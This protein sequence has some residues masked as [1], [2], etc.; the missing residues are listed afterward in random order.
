MD[1]RTKHIRL[2]R[3]V[4]NRPQLSNILS[5]INVRI[6]N[7]AT[8]CALKKL[9][10]SI[11][12]TFTHTTSF[13]GIAR[14]NNSHNNPITLSLVLK[15]RSQLCKG[16]R[17]MLS[18]LRLSDSSSLSDMCQVFNGY[19]FDF[20]HGLL[21]DAF[22]DSVIGDS[23]VSLFSAFKPFQELLSSLRAFA[24]NTSTNFEILISNFIKVFRII[25]C[26]IG[27]NGNASYT[28]IYSNKF[29]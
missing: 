22:T 21:Y 17:V 5:G 3:A 6:S 9:A 14:V 26:P 28:K 20:R 15:E 13:A 1:R 4:Y 12:N 29:F 16:P 27:E 10:V 23:G 25:T 11:A 19:S 8:A 7:I 24:L 2:F 18:S